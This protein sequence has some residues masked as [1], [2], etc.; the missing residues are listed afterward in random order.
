MQIGR[1]QEPLA[2]PD[3]SAS[4]REH[5]LGQRLGSASHD[6]ASDRQDTRPSRKHTARSAQ[7]APFAS[8]NPQW[9][10]AA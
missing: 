7:Q 3:R 1:A 10:L 9:Y 4:S 5:R 2:R 6:W 8:G